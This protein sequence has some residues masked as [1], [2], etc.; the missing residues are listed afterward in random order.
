MDNYQKQRGENICTDLFWY[1]LKADWF[2][3]SFGELFLLF[4]NKILRCTE[5]KEIH[6]ITLPY[7]QKISFKTLT[8]REIMGRKI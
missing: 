2:I 7:W 8:S 3:D 5:E 4:N 6:D 1:G